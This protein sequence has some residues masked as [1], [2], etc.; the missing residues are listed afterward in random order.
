MVDA[1][2]WCARRFYHARYGLV[3][4]FYKINFL[5]SGARRGSLAGAV[6]EKPG[7]VQ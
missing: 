3:K 2:R 6:H 5:H 4:G 7:R 1:P